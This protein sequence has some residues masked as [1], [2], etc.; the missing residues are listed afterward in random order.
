[1]AE[2]PHRTFRYPEGGVEKM[3]RAQLVE[4]HCGRALL[5]TLRGWL[6]SV[7]VKVEGESACSGG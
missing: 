7:P 3:E 4:A 2:S 6:M 1:V 5:R